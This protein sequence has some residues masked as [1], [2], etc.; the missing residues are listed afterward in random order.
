MILRKRALGSLKKKQITI[1]LERRSRARSI[2]LL[3]IFGCVILSGPPSRAQDLQTAYQQAASS[4]P[5]I[6]QAR[7][8]LDADSAGKQ[9][10]RAALLPHLNGGASGGMNTARVTGFGAEPIS[11]GYHSDVFSVSLTESIFNG[12]AFT[13]L[14]QSNSRIQASEAALAYAQQVIALEVTQAYFGVLEA[15]ANERVAKQQTD[16]LRSIDKQTETNLH[17]GTGDIISV[18][19]V[20]AQLDAAKADLTSATNAVTV[21][22]NQLERLTHQPVGT[23]KDVT[24][25]QAIGPQPNTIDPWLATALRNQP[26][27]QQAKATLKVSEQQVQFAKRARWPTLSLSGIGQHAAGTLIPPITVNQVGASLNLSIP[28]YEGGSTGAEIRQAEA[29]SEASRA[30]I[31]NLQDQITLNTQTA[32]HDLQDSV[33]QFEARQEAVTSAKVS[34][35]ATRKGYEIGS[36]SII[37]LLTATTNYASAQRNYYLALYTQLVARAQLKA[38]AGILTPADIQAI[39]DLLAGSPSK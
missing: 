37:D 28:I 8:Q 22:K 18:Q 3:L 16:L 26:L 34:L 13:A 5:I 15:Q 31:A 27:L 38:A 25:L 36:R 29:L 39:N 23:L 32:F 7:A 12:Q 20:Q 6:A 35:E 9:L 17:V 2:T 10:A 1:P 4:S 24:T 11:T 30:N 21:A 19:E 33:A 14:K